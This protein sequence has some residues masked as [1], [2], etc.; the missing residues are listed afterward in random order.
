ME[1]KEISMKVNGLFFD[2]THRQELAILVPVYKSKP[3]PLEIV[4]LKRIAEIFRDRKVFFL[5]PSLLNTSW[6]EKNFSE[7]EIERL[8]DRWFSSLDTYNRMLL[9]ESFYQKWLECGFHSVLICQLDV[10]VIF[11]GLDD[12]L[13]MPYDYIGAPLFHLVQ[14]S[15]CFYGG[16]GGFSLR[17]LEPCIRMLKM[18]ADLLKKWNENED[19]FFS[20]CG[21][22]FPKEFHVAPPNTSSQ[23]AFDRF[24]RILYRRNR[25]N[26]PLA[27]HGWCTYDPS[28]SLELIGMSDEFKSRYNIKDI[29]KTEEDKCLIFAKAYQPII[30][31]GAGLW[32]KVF[33]RYLRK[34]GISVRCFVVSD[35]Q[36]TGSSY[37]G[38]EVK[39]LSE[40][41][42]DCLAS[43]M[44]FS[45]SK[46]FIGAK[47]FD[48]IFERV[49]RCGF[50]HCFEFNTVLFNLAV[51]SWMEDYDV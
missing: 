27:I 13:T 3:E 29:R 41:G 5:A 16:N 6:Y 44:M 45:V 46:R 34:K 50:E 26:L 35:G 20:Y 30:L 19:E 1:E 33:F 11:D 43:G 32:G 47:C 48:A 8:D 37:C 12:Y 39:R 49:K 17:K 4:A 22:N 14:D 18:H 7:M 31:Y 51:E 21:E 36:P 9:S 23:F 24:S 15:P 38:V 40:L 25:K 28:F 2:N 42:E 10:Y